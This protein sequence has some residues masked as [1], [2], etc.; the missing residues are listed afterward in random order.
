MIN[1]FYDL[2]ILL[3]AW[4]IPLNHLNKILFFYLVL[5]KIN[6]YVIQCYHV[7]SHTILLLVVMHAT[8]KNAL[9]VPDVKCLILMLYPV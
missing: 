7:L 2:E 3:Y 9:L 1:L 4:I 5:Q 6:M 8:T